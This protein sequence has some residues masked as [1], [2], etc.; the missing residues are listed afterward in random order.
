MRLRL[1]VRLLTSEGHS[2]SHVERLRLDTD[3]WRLHGGMLG[4]RVAIPQME[5]ACSADPGGKAES[6]FNTEQG[7][8]SDHCTTQHTTACP[9]TVDKRSSAIVFHWYQSGTVDSTGFCKLG[10][11]WSGPRAPMSDTDHT[12]YVL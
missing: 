2:G 12:G 6:F 5:C 9:D 11:M 1:G 3:G 8:C 7:V 10:Q 4:V